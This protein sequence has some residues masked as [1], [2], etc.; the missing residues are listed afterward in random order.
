MLLIIII[1]LTGAGYF[2]LNF[3]LKEKAERIRINNNL[4]NEVN[5]KNEVY[6]KLNVKVKELELVKPKLDSAIRA[7]KIR[8][9]HVQKV[10]IYE[11][12]TIWDTIRFNLH[13]PKA[14]SS[15]QLIIVAGI[16][17]CFTSEGLID[18]TKTRLA[19]SNEDVNNIQFTLFN[20]K[21]VDNGGI[22]YYCARDT[23]KRYQRILPFW[24]FAKKKFYSKS[25]SDCN[26]T[27]KIQEIN[28]IKK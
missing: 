1:L 23:S 4:I 19:P 15:N 5:A 16:D 21:V 25:Y 6:T 10:I 12:K 8:P 3:A 17:N 26:S 20:T 28:F 9:K 22:I 24:P 2:A 7:N 27:T 13:P 18:L 11:T 14:D